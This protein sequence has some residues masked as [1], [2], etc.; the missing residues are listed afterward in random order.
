MAGMIEI[1]LLGGFSLVHD[2]SLIHGL[3]APRIQSLLAYLL[4]QREMPQSRQHLAFLSWPDSA[5]AQA[6]TNLR[7]LLHQLVQA[8]PEAKHYLPH[9]P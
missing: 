1:R 3:G 2:G 7:K 6:R 9:R 5:E 8:L 4:L